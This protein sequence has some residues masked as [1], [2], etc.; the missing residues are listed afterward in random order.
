LTS[1]DVQPVNSTSVQLTWSLS[2]SSIID[3]YTLSV[4]RLCDNMVLPELVVDGSVTSRV[5]SMLSSGFQY[6]GR[7]IPVNILGEGMERTG[8]VTLEE[9]SKYCL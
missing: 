4:T 7:I 3:N 1:F 6:G 9:T 8:S 2:D 5:I